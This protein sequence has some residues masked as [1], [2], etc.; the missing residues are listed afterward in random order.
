MDE[1]VVSETELSPKEQMLLQEEYI[2]YLSEVRSLYR[3]YRY[4]QRGYL[5]DEQIERLN[6]LKQ[7]IDEIYAKLPDEVKPMYTPVKC[8]WI[9]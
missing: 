7:K 8:W 3:T 5:S 9:T 1:L 6:T 4:E 2:T